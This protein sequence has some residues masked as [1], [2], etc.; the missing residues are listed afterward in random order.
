MKRKA[1]CTAAQEESDDSSDNL[2]MVA[3][4]PANK[5][6][7]EKPA[8]VEE[9]ST[10]LRAGESPMSATGKRADV[11]KRQKE[12]AWMDSDEDNE[13]EENV[14]KP[15]AKTESAKQAQDSE[16]DASGSEDEN[17]DVSAGTL[18]GVET[19]GRMMVLAP[20]L[21]KKLP[22]MLP[23]DAAAACRALSRTKFFDND[24]I[25]A[26]SA[27]LKRL[28][29]RDRL[30]VEQADDVLRC[31]ASLNV[32]DEGVFSAVA[33]QMKVRTASLDQAVRGQWFEIYKGF[34]HSGDKDFYQLLEVP[35]LNALSPGYKRLRCA[36]HQR[37]YCAVGEACT[38]SHD[39]RAPI[40]LESAYARPVSKV[41]MTQTQSNMGRDVYGGAR[42]GQMN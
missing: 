5:A 39:P 2:R 12:F 23:E 7:A 22:R 15:E 31:M 28:L 36:H 24:I 21:L 38:Y 33:R 10:V 4:I 29:L 14:E 9:P 3:K 17:A 16:D 13:P 41:M 8:T 27:V 18:D 19:F 6:R 30:S 40:E 37:G 25:R 1:I 35:H 42:N 26:L 11:P 34:K 20:A 32:Y